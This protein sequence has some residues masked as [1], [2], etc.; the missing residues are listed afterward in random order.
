MTTKSY[1]APLSGQIIGSIVRELRLPGDVLT[2]KTALRYFKGQR[3]KDD[4]KHEIFNAI[5]TALVDSGIIPTMPFL[6]GSEFPRE[7]AFSFGLACYADQWDNLVGYMR[8]A[9]AP[10]DRPDLAAVSY[11]R[12]ATIDLALRFS[13]ALWLAELPAPGEE[14]PLWAEE[15][16]GAKYL[17][18]LLDQCGATRPTRDQLAEQLEVSYTTVDNW[19]DSNI[20]P[21]RINTDRLAVE[22]SGCIADCDAQTLKSRMHR[23]FALCSL[24]DLLATHLGRDTVIDLATALVRFTSR[25]L[26]GLRLFSKLPPDEAA[27]RQFFILLFGSQFPSTEYLLKHLWRRESSKVWRTD[28][29]AAPKPWHLRLTH[30]ARHLGG[31][32]EVVQRM[33]IEY[34][35]PENISKELLEQSLIDIQS[36]LT[37]PDVVHPSKLEGMTVVR[38]KG[39]AKYSAGNRMIQYDQ[40][41]SEGDLG[42]AIIHVARAVE[43][44]PENAEYHFHLGATLGMAGDIEAGIQECWI[45]SQ[46]APDYELPLVEVGIILLNA[47]RNEEAHK[48]LENVAMGRD[49]LSA[50]LAFNLGIARMR[51]GDPSRALIAL[52]QTIAEVPDNAL[53]L[54][55]AAHCA[56]LIG[57]KVRGRSLAKEA[58]RLGEY[59][60]YR[61]WLN[62]EYRTTIHPA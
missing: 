53:A 31:H 5:A 43:L 17:R 60:T 33:Q 18:Q 51:V 8:S 6:D 38:I 3:V 58:S 56:F 32:A 35:I 46:L 20:R 62:G 29:M 45:A 4:S 42:T 14:T 2:S 24:G 39:D 23:H 41:R 19:L 21:S 15:R 50:H 52:E 10:V 49:T 59:D 22:L 26:T 27:M 9:S 40:A 37:R 16:G 25:N 1:R 11:L 48:H 55:A 36:D 57:H 30:I 13:A 47:G 28:L 44:Q 34:G 54:D 7:K 12:L 61:A